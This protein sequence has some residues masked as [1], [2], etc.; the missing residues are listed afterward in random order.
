MKTYIVK[1]N[2]KHNGTEYIVGDEIEMNGKQ[3]KILVQDGVLMA[4]GKSVKV[5]EE[6]DKTEEPKE[7]S[8]GKGNKGGNK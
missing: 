2:L 8:K 7:D 1:S 3:A 5:K 4:K 6:T